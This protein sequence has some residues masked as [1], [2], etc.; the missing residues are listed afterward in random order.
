MKQKLNSVTH[1]RY[2]QKPLAAK[3]HPWNQRIQHPHYQRFLLVTA[4]PNAK[5]LYTFARISFPSKEPSMGKVVKINLTFCLAIS[6]GQACYAL[7]PERPI[8]FKGLVIARRRRNTNSG[9]ELLDLGI[10]V[11]EIREQHFRFTLPPELSRYEHSQSIQDCDFIFPTENSVMYVVFSPTKAGR[12]SAKYQG[13]IAGY[14]T[15]GNLVSNTNDHA[16]QTDDTASTN[17]LQRLPIPPQYINHPS[18]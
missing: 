14:Y 6:Y 15:S 4:H 17:R 13:Y 5:A 11:T 16:D 1:N 2:H 18:L 10:E 8:T 12:R 7:N 9:N 3:K